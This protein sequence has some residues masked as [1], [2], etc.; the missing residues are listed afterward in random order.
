MNHRIKRR[1]FITLIAG[2]A[3]AP[4]IWPLAAR[5]QQ[6]AKVPRLGVLL[7]STP[8][9]DPQM[10][11]ARRALSDIGYVEGKN[12]AIEYRYAEGKA[13]RLPDLAAELVAAKP[14]VLFSIGGD[15]TKAAVKATRAIPIVFTSSAD[16]VQLEFVAS[17]ARPGGNATGVTLLLDELASKRLEIFKEAAPQV[18]RVAF[19]FNPDHIDNELREAERAARTL[20]VA[21][22]PLA[23]HRPA[24]IEGALRAAAE[25]RAD[26]LYVVSSRLTVRYINTFTDFAAK[27]RLPLAGGWGAWAQAG[28]LLSYGPTVDDM[29]RRATG[30][31]DKV[32]KGSKPADLPVQQPTKFELV[33]NLK[34]AKALGLTIP[35]SFLLRAD[36]VIE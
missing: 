13:E 1:D 2:A 31:V 12:L 17:L 8:Q 15:V 26:G 24:D 21:L 23:V 4:V 35:E 6:P 25:A 32:L 18:S 10:E 29:V 36:R 28:G 7:F 16:P 3:A 5:A 11:A 27:S 22:Q 19:L 9:T 33:I 34:T 20:G 14:D 30:Y